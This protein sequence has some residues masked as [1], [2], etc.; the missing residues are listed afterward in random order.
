MICMAFH[1]PIYLGMHKNFSGKKIPK[2]KRLK[3]FILKF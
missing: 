1:I 3:N 2:W